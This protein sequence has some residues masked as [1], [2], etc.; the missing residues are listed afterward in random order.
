M[1]TIKNKRREK[2][3]IRVVVLLRKIGVSNLMEE[4]LECL[5]KLVC[6]VG[7]ENCRRSSLGTISKWHA[8]Y[9]CSPA[10]ISLDVK[11]ELHKAHR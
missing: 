10:D 11:N 7:W 2:R 6:E 1:C 8:R 5:N 4:A 3:G 9:C